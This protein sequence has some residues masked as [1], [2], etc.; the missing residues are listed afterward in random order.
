VA[1]PAPLRRSLA[2][3]GPRALNGATETLATPGAGRLEQSVYTPVAPGAG[4]RAIRIAS[5]KR[6]FAAAVTGQLKLRL[7]A[8][9]R[10]KLHKV[11]NVKLAIVTRFTHATARRSLSRSG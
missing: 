11:K 8:A 5:G 9:G 6:S 2:R 3:R 4:R 7:T 10:R 1:T